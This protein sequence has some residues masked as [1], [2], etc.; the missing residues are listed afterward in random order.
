MESVLKDAQQ[1]DPRLHLLASGGHPNEAGHAYWTQRLYDF[2][3]ER[4]K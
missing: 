1:S 3:K 4:I 2:A